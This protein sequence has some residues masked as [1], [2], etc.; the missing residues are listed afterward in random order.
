MRLGPQKTV[1]ADNTPVS[2]DSK[3]S[4]PGYSFRKLD[5]GQ[6]GISRYS[7]STNGSSRLSCPIPNSAR[8][9]RAIV[10]ASVLK[11]RRRAIVAP[12]LAFE[13]VR[14]SP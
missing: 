5:I 4:I 3:C 6:I 14:R 13:G 12:T 2:T 8:V 10:L 11:P 7:A 9:S 1:K